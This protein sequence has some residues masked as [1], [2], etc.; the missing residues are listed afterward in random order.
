MS[1]I[2]S[3]D[4]ETANLDPITSGPFWPAIDPQAFREYMRQ[5]TTIPDGRL[6]QLLILAI[7]EVND[8]LAA[9]QA[10]QTAGTLAEVSATQVAGES[11]KV[12]GYRHAVYALAKAQLVERYRDFD[13]TQSG[14]QR[15]DEMDDTIDEY[16]RDAAW[17]I[18]R[19]LERPRTVVE[20]I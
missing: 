4:G 7:A 9:W 8:R 12:I 13:S 17:Q 1:L 3:G 2:A 11:V 5:D 15:A 19:I 16:R 20:L 6:Q 10:T 14:H 18:A